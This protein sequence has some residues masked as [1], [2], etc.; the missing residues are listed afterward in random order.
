MQRFDVLSRQLNIR[1]SHLLEAS[2]GTG[3]TFAI[4]HLVIRLL[5]EGKDPLLLE[6]ILVVTFTRAATRELKNRIHG[7]LQKARAFLRG[8]GLEG[9]DYLV[10]WKEKGEEASREAF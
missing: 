4:E 3:K 1:G 5:L 9:W 8:E 10:A 6:E 2:A 7:N